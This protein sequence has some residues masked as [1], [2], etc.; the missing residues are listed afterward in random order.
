MGTAGGVPQPGARRVAALFV[1]KHALD[2]ED[3]FAPGV[4]VEREGGAGFP[5][6]Q[7]HRLRAEAVQRQHRQP[8]HQPGAPRRRRCVHRE[9]PLI[10]RMHLAQFHE[11]GAALLTEGGMGRAGGVAQV[12]AGRVVARVV[13]EQAFQ[14][15]DLLAGIVAVLR[16]AAAGGVA[17]DRGGPRH[18]AAVALQQAPFHPGGGR[19]RPGQG[20]GGDHRPL[21][22]IR[23]VSHSPI[24]PLTSPAASRPGSGSSP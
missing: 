5:A 17:H 7:G 14:H 9:L 6:H 18:F 23:V 12:G 13:G 10:G 3:L 24:V 21:L 8:W 20:A 11:Q 2:H 1:F 15:Q 16:E 19:G 22:E 4:A